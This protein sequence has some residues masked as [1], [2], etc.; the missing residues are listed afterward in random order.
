MFNLIVSGRLENDRRGS[1]P[2]ERVFENTPEELE[3][4]FMRSGILDISGVMALPTL[5]W[6]KVLATKSLGLGG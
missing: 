4:R 6:K 2:A 5:F 3:D 1:I